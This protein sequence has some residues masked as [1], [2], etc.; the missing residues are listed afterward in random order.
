ML[1]RGVNAPEELTSIEKSYSS[2]SR[3]CSTDLLTYIQSSNVTPLSPSIKILIEL[4]GE[5]SR[6]IKKYEIR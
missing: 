3:L 2:L 4:S 6:S 1:E 5:I